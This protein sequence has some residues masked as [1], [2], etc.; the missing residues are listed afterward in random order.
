[1]TDPDSLIIEKVQENLKNYIDQAKANE[2]KILDI[3]GFKSLEEMQ[4]K[5]LNYSQFTGLEKLTGPY[6]YST[7]LRQYEV[8]YSAND[9]DFYNWVQNIFVPRYVKEIE[10]KIFSPQELQKYAQAMIGSLMEGSGGSIR[11]TGNFDFL[12]INGKID[13]SKLT[14]NRIARLEEE[15]KKETGKIPPSKAEMELEWSSDQSGFNIKGTIN[16]FGITKG[17]KK[18]DKAVK[19]LENDPN[20]ITQLKEILVSEIQNVLSESGTNI[21]KTIIDKVLGKNA[22]DL[23]EFFV[24]G[25]VNKITGLLGEF[26]AA[27]MIAHFLPNFNITEDMIEWTAN[28]TLEGTNKEL[29]VD[30]IV[31]LTNNF[32]IGVQVK[33]TT[34]DLTDLQNSNSFF[35]IDFAD[36]DINTIFGRLQE[37]YPELERYSDTIKDIYISSS[38]N[39]PYTVKSVNGQDI[40][41]EGEG[42]NKLSNYDTFIGV[43]GEIQNL[44][45]KIDLFF[46]TLSPDLLFMSVN[47]DFTNSLAILDEK[48]A[49]VV[50][51]N[52]LYII[53]NKP[54]FV[55]TI[56]ESIYNDLKLIDRMIIEV[57]QRKINFQNIDKE[58]RGLFDK[59]ET[60][61]DGNIVS[62]KNKYGNTGKGQDNWRK[63]KA[64]LKAQRYQ[65]T[66]SYLY[67]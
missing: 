60:L 26:S 6:L 45:N 57:T 24:G 54:I 15:Y 42:G 61:A 12:T 10:G 17:L 21:S 4:S 33:N 19:D 30:F 38:F 49:K 53:G 44:K 36:A 13:F 16:Y 37:K 25:N 35:K 58:D 1:M 23:K 27:V 32:S 22:S 51:G 46:Q 65:F 34:Q 59:K 64:N 18:S 3:F 29:S 48:A 43:K 41:I 55:S 5:F 66:S 52:N 14:E 7:V 8:N 20:K 28:R 31:N 67:Q 9:A 63:T 11:N 39:V 50:Q 56:L 62:Y 2:Q 40:Y 47:E